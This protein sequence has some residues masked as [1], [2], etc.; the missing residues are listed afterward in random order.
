MGE[1][2]YYAVDV[3]EEAARLQETPERVRE[4]LATG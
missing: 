3:E 4:M 2:A 1:S